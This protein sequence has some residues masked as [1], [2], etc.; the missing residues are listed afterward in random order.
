M[1]TCQHSTT[2][3]AAQPA[4]TSW[5]TKYCTGLELTVWITVSYRHWMC[6][7]PEDLDKYIDFMKK[8]LSGKGSLP[9]CL[10]FHRHKDM[11][12]DLRMLP[13]D[14]GIRWAETIQETK[15]VMVV[16]P[17]VYH[18]GFNYGYV[19]IYNIYKQYIQH[20]I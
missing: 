17:K 7:H 13:F 8:K 5:F 4:L 10:S 11:I 18:Q 1:V 20:C 6:I 16:F 2:L 14:L 3:L 9:D 12:V 19:S 15:E